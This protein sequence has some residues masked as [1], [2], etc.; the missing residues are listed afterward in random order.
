MT[1][2]GPAS[3]FPAMILAAG[4][5]ERMRPLTEHTPKP[6]LAVG[7]KPLIVWQIERLRA[8]GFVDLVINHAHLGERI[9]Q[10]L[11]DGTALDVRIRY[12]REPQPLETAGGIATALALLG[13]TPF[14][15]AN[16]DVYTEF[17][18]ARLLPRLR[19]MA[20]DPAHLAHLVLVDNPPQHAEGDFTLDGERVL[21][22]ATAGNL[23]FSGL[24]CYRPELFAGIAPGDKAK[25]A[26][27]LRGA[28][29][30]GKV[31]GEHFS[32]RWE[33]VGTPA[34]LAALDRELE[35]AHAA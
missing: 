12:S 27:L 11:A 9:E 14:V 18:Y 1:R 26:P 32:G 19:A 23:T 3:P 16:G 6:L 24:A 31:S 10:H 33:D 28:I 29:A 5:G 15:V 30:A 13:E 20:N 7:G 25:L 35:L 8:A 34:R 22:A 2:P 17:D 21:P 4:F